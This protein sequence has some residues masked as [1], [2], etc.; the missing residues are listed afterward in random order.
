[1]K[2]FWNFLWDGA[3]KIGT[4][5]LLT[6]VVILVSSLFSY[7]GQGVY[8]RINGP[9]TTYGTYT[10]VT[11]SSDTFV[12]DTFYSDS[13]KIP[14]NPDYADYNYMVVT[15]IRDTII[16]CDSCNDSVVVVTTVWT[17]NDEGY[18]VQLASDAQAADLTNDTASMRFYV[19]ASGGVPHL[20][21]L[22]RDWIWIRTI[23][24]DSVITDIAVTGT[25]YK[26][27]YYL[28][29]LK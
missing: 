2:K 3:N 11:D 25:D 6:V 17:R 26:A 29:F 21:S 4:L 27:R 15:L 19:N 14:D 20:D 9:P 5:L 13:F 16:L 8:L 7:G 12:V 18:N 1:M 24:S 28:W 22:V 23:I 10:M